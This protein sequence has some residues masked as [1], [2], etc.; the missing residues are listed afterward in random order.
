[1]GNDR[2]FQDVLRDLA[3]PKEQGKVEGFFNSAENAGKLGSLVEDIRNAMMEYQVCTSSYYS[4]LRCP[5][6]VSDVTA[7]R[8]LR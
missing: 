1:M 4:F 7:A 6:S 5:T 2:K 8:D 3:P